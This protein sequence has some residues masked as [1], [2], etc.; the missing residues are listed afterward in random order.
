MT[1]T[2]IV[3]EST[4]SGRSARD[5]KTNKTSLGWVI[6][7]VALA[8]LVFLFVFPFL[9]MLLTSF[10]I[11]ADIFHAPPEF[12]PRHWTLHNF[13]SAFQQ[14]PLL[15]YLFNTALIA[16]LSVLGTLISCPL[17]A[18]SLSKIH[19]VGRNA[20]FVIIIATMMIPPQVTMI[21]LYLLWNRSGLSGTILPLVVPTFL[22]TPYLIY[23]TRQFLMSVPNELVEAGRIDGANEF[24]IYWSIVVPIIRP[25]L[26]TAAVFQFVWTWTDFLNPLLYLT[27]SKQYTLSLGLYSFFSEHGVAWGPLMAAC[28][29][30]TAPAVI[31][32]VLAQRYFVGGLA[33]GAVK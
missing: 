18:Y 14:I 1:T 15:R 12:L 9:V 4:R 17:V 2:E 33:A 3:T 29:L 19:W 25:A 8:L 26:V 6:Q 22:G 16:V 23:M 27:D 21:P 20:L 7:R 32:F 28:V 13:V 10:K 30:F 5:P 24:R 31:V 11:N